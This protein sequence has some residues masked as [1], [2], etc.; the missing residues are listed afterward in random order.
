MSSIARI[1]SGQQQD[2][3]DELN[4]WADLPPGYLPLPLG[5]DLGERLEASQR[6]LL[7]IAP[8]E[9]RDV[10]SAVSDTFTVLLE[11]LQARNVAY[12][13]LGWHT[14]E[15][16]AVVSST[17]IMSVQ[18]FPAA[19]NPRIL[20]KDLLET[21]AA[22]AEHGQADLVDLANGPALFFEA[23]RSLP[24]PRI[25]GQPDPGDARARVYQLQATVPNEKGTA[26]AVAEF[27]TPMVEY[28]PFYREMMVLLANSLSFN[29]PPGSSDAGTTARSISKILGGL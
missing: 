29:P 25:P 7:D 10:V 1:L 3:D 28:G 12:C 22:H 2:K 5:Q 9:Q 16:G 8:A 19:L 26:F 20:L 18:R 15:D 11:E 13:G 6:I 4:V 17:L 24:Q 14:A 27:S 21:K 23:V